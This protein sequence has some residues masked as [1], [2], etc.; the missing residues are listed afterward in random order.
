MGLTVAKLT[1]YGRANSSTA[2][3]KVEERNQRDNKGLVPRAPGSEGGRR[4]IEVVCC[5]AHA[6]AEYLPPD[7]I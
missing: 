1:Q 5:R 3:P 2:V 6:Q 7:V 4:A